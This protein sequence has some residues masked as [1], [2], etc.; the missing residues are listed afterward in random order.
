[1]SSQCNRQPADLEQL[2]DLKLKDSD[3][4]ADVLMPT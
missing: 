2:I 4:V 3:V 1:M